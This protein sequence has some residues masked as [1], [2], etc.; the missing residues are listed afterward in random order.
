[1]GWSA[2]HD[3]LAVKLYKEDLK[4]FG[5]LPHGRCK[6]VAVA[7]GVLWPAI[8]LA[9]D[10]SRA[11][12]KKL[13]KLFASGGRLRSR[14]F[15]VPAP[16][17]AFSAGEDRRLKALIID[18]NISDKSWAS[19]A[20]DKFSNR[21]RFELQSRGRMLCPELCGWTQ[22]CAYGL[23]RGHR[24]TNKLSDRPRVSFH[25][26]P[27]TKLVLSHLGFADAQWTNRLLC[28]S[29]HGQ[30][31]A[32][33]LSADNLPHNPSGEPPLPLTP[34]KRASPLGDAQPGSRQRRK[35]EGRELH[36]QQKAA[37]E[38]VAAQ[39]K[40]LAAATLL[41]QAGGGDAIKAV[42][43]LSEELEGLKLAQAQVIAREEAQQAMLGEL[44]RWSRSVR[45][46]SWEDV[47]DDWVN[48]WT[49]FKSKV[50]AQV[51]F[52]VFIGP[53]VTDFESWT[54]Y[55]KNTIVTPI[56]AQPGAPGADDA[57]DSE[58][59]DGGGGKVVK[60]SAKR[61][62]A[63]LE[64]DAAF[65]AAAIGTL[66][67]DYV[68]RVPKARK[69]VY[70]TH[71]LGNVQLNEFQEFMVLMIYLRRG[72]D[73]DVLSS[74]FFGRTDDDAV[75]TVDSI[76][77]T[78]ATA[79]HEILKAEDWW[80]SDEKADA[81]RT[82]SFAFSDDDAARIKAIADC[83]N[84]NSQG[85]QTNELLRQ[86]LYSTYY[87]HPCSKYCVA[88]SVIGGCMACSAGQGGPADDHQCMVDGMDLFN[89]DKWEVADGKSWSQ[90][91]YDAGVSRNTKQCAQRSK[92]DM[93]CSGIVRKSAKSSL[94][95][96]QR[97]ENFQT[98]SLRIRVENFIGIVKQRFKVLTRV[99]SNR[100][101]PIM[102][103]LVYVCFMLHNF[104]HP[105]I[106]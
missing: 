29:D 11:L 16:K 58:S 46:S 21:T 33:P 62:A 23:V 87:K 31:A 57:A 77:R 39:K 35:E 83:S 1:M 15:A 10:N 86:Q 66:P 85:S 97:K 100:D 78:W 45:P 103:K 95:A 47:D 52:E 48:T 5:D 90:L 24:C 59:S 14:V 8:M 44:Q 96:I 3:D 22:Q 105:I 49:P 76:I 26:V 65:R 98:S 67:A 51:F 28:C 18:A 6:R 104:G 93:C 42:A 34:A 84:V 38:A 91:L 55:R 68:K 92:C 74:K 36:A 4:T 73:K 64:R 75:R 80:L 25:P 20:K 19:W 81:V 61:V 27:R 13:Q 70:R 17:V 60:K 7:G 43:L 106:K 40:S 50:V 30:N 2:T 99:H 37:D 63:R 79:C 53:R 56:L 41:V 72:L 88:C 32:Q 82:H 54:K 69:H 71:K 9:G 102:D 101:F 12:D 89:P 94:S